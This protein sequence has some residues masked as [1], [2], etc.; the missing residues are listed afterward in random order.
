MSDF[1][2]Y[3]PLSPLQMGPDNDLNPDDIT[4]RMSYVPGGREIHTEDESIMRADAEL[5]RMDGPRMQKSSVDGGRAGFAEDL[6]QTPL[7]KL[8]ILGVSIWLMMGVLDLM[9]N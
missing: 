3:D 5:T 7:G 1:N 6:L 4:A 8:L 2:H 9:R